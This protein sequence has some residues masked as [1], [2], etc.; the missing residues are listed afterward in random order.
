[1]IAGTCERITPLSKPF[2]V[3]DKN[4]AKSLAKVD[5]LMFAGV[6]ARITSLANLLKIS[7]RMSMFVFVEG[8][9][10]MMQLYVHV[11]LLYPYDYM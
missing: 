3:K 5:E 7:V 8:D 9:E 10:P 6:S 1:M 4:E 2:F 11:S